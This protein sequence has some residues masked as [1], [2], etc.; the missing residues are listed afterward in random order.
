MTLDGRLLRSA[1]SK[2]RQRTK[3]LKRRSRSIPTRIWNVLLENV[4]RPPT[5]GALCSCALVTINSLRNTSCSCK[6]ITATN[7]RL[8]RGMPP[9]WVASGSVQCRRRHCTNALKSNASRKKVPRSGPD[10]K[11]VIDCLTVQRVRNIFAEYVAANRM[12]TLGHRDTIGTYIAVWVTQTPLGP[13]WE[14]H[15]GGG[16]YPAATCEGR[17]FHRP[18]H[19][20]SHTDTLGH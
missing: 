18:P 8:R 9:S 4:V 5:S 15:V 17:P 12:Q 7:Y 13:Y 2:V 11:C 6:Y 20:Q 10:Q 14:Q 16:P 19:C 1:N 3:G